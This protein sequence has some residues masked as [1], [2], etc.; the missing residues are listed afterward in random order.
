MARNNLRR[1]QSNLNAC[2]PFLTVLYS[3]QPLPILPLHQND[4]KQA[5]G[6]HILL[7]RNRAGFDFNIERRHQHISLFCG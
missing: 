5:T 7:S 4:R 1:V 2:F 3:S 6:L